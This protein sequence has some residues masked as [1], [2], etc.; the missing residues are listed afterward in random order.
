MIL[1]VF[2]VMYQVATIAIQRKKIKNV[3]LESVFLFLISLGLLS[4]S[5]LFFVYMATPNDK[6]LALIVLINLLALNSAISLAF[7]V[8]SNSV[9]RQ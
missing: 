7:F 6:G 9:E 1:I 5:L 4:F 2:L 3:F 8:G